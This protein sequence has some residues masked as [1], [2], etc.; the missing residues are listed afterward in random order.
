M[1]T[2]KLIAEAGASRASRIRAGAEITKAF[3]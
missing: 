1:R 2:A 3:K